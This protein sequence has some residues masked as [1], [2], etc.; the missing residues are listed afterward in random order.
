M[1]KERKRERERG[2]EKRKNWKKLAN[3][4]FFFLRNT[5]ERCRLNNSKTERPTKVKC[6]VEFVQQIRKTKKKELAVNGMN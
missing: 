2:E 3:F 6:V 5:K 1:L 4:F